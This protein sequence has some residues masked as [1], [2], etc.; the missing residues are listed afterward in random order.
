VNDVV[1]RVTVMLRILFFNDPE[2]AAEMEVDDSQGCVAYATLSEFPVL[3]IPRVGEEL[4]TLGWSGDMSE[5]LPDLPFTLRI[6]SVEHRV[7]G[8]LA[9]GEPAI[10]VYANAFLEDISLGLIDGLESLGFLFIRR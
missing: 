8:G 3:S 10:C 7:S 1:P 6:C 4:V 2:T 5:A 9:H